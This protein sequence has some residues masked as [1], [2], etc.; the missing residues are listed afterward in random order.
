MNFGSPNSGLTGCWGEKVRPCYFSVIQIQISPETSKPE[1]ALCLAGLLTA[2][3]WSQQQSYGLAPQDGLDI[4]VVAVH[5]M[6]RIPNNKGI[7]E[8]MTTLYQLCGD[9]PLMHPLIAPL[10]LT[11]C[12]SC[13]LSCSASADVL[14]Y[15]HLSCSHR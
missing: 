5:S 3:H 2:K 7:T 8:D 15:A 9:E 13:F 11:Y 10:A 12:A 1:R 4:V 14:F 6:H